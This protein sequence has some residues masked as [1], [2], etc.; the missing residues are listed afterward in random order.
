[1]SQRYSRLISVSPPRTPAGGAGKAE[2]AAC[3]GEDRL[4]LDS[5]STAPNSRCSTPGDET[6]GEEGGRTR[7]L[8]GGRTRTSVTGEGLEQAPEGH[9]VDDHPEGSAKSAGGGAQEGRHEAESGSADV[10]KRGVTLTLDSGGKQPEGARDASREGNSGSGQEAPN[11][12]STSD[13]VPASLPPAADRPIG[14]NPGER[15]GVGASVQIEGAGDVPAPEEAGKAGERGFTFAADVGA[16]GCMRH[17]C[18]WR[19]GGTGYVAAV[20]GWLWRRRGRWG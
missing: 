9:K 12:A 6:T 14:D 16:S 19:R 4:S 5:A 3:S 13:V 8:E 20:D 18:Y 7:G 15:G 17:Q 11:I 10:G 1:M 2:A